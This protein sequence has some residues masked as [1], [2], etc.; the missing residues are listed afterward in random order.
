VAK[1]AWGVIGSA[2][3]LVHPV[4]TAAGTDLVHVFIVWEFSR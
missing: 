3:V 1:D 2:C 4:M